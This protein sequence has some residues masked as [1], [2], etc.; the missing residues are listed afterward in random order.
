VTVAR[1]RDGA[2]Q[3]VQLLAADAYGLLAT[4]AETFS[5][6]QIPERDDFAAA[7]LLLVGDLNLLLRTRGFEG[8]PRRCA[9]AR[10]HDWERLLEEL[11]W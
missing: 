11:A 6:R 8:A 9:A 1:G 10:K 3:L 5:P 2:V 7:L 4:P